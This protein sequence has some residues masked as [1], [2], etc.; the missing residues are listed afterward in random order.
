M[1]TRKRPRSGQ[2]L[3]LLI[4]GGFA[5]YGG[6]ALPGAKGVIS[7][8]VTPANIGEITGERTGYSMSGLQYCGSDEAFHYLALTPY[9]LGY[10]PPVKWSR[11]HRYKMPIGDL[12]VISPMPRSG[13]P[14]AWKPL[15]TMVS[16]SEF[17][18][19]GVED[20]FRNLSDLM[21]RQPEKP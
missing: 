8:P 2:L 4:T 10:L 19:L 21:M 18:A 12:E 20:P 6:C 13:D 9:A 17:D 3:L 7:K 1:T 11:Y 5:A 15:S 16:P 14:E